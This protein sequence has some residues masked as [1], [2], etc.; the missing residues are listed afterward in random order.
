M[1]DL[2]EEEIQSSS[3]NKGCAIGCGVFILAIVLIVMFIFIKSSMPVTTPDLTG[4]TLLEATN[5][6]K[7]LGLD[8]DSISSESI[9]GVS[10]WD[11]SNWEVCKQSIA[12]G[13]KIKKD[14]KIDF[15]VERDCSKVT[16]DGKL[17]KVT[18][19]NVKEITLDK[20]YSILNKKLGESIQIETVDKTK[21]DRG[22]WDDEAWIV[23]DQSPKANEKI[24]PKGVVTLKYA[25]DKKECS[26]GKITI[27]KEEKELNSKN[28]ERNKET[29]SGLDR[30]SSRGMCD[31]WLDREVGPGYSAR[32]SQG[33][34][35]EDIVDEGNG[36]IWQHNVIVKNDGSNVGTL[37]CKV[38]GSIDKPRLISAKI[39]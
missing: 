33:L 6:M 15:K 36:E 31:H 9:S 23:C 21:E 35:Y 7:D 28:K 22:V 11:S 16:N 27:T 37:I 14:A 19:P 34:K 10:I 17:K 13:T 24:D 3:K 2:S 29:K 39:N 18:V 38:S 1:G 25:R 4:K 26:T 32:W 8:R 20:A 5:Q 12:A 30:Y